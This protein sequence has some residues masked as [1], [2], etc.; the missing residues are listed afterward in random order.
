[1]IS[2]TA[3]KEFEGR[4]LAILDV[5]GRLEEAATVLRA[6]IARSRIKDVR[7]KLQD[8]RFNIA[9]VGGYKRGK[10]TFVNALLGSEILPTGIVPLTSVITKIVSGDMPI[11]TKASC[12]PYIKATVSPATNIASEIMTFPTF[13]PI[14]P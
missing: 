4:K 7:T 10:S 14:P 9:V 8:E 13:S 5:A 2:S 3:L 12:H 6:N 11:N 1:M